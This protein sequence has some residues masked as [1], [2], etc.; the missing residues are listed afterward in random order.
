MFVHNIARVYLS[1]LFLFA[2]SLFGQ[3]FTQREPV[4]TLVLS[5]AGDVYMSDEENARNVIEKTNSFLYQDLV[6]LLHG[7]DASF[8]DLNSP[9]TNAKSQRRPANAHPNQIEA[10]VNA[11]FDV[12]SLANFD[13]AQQGLAGLQQ[14]QESWQILWQRFPWIRYS[15]LK[16]NASESIKATI[17]SRKNKNI[18]L[19]SFVQLNAQE[20]EKNQAFSLINAVDF[21]NQ[22]EWSRLLAYV[23]SL[24]TQADLIIVS[25]H[26][27]DAGIEETQPWQKA[28]RALIDAGADIVWNHHRA[29]YKKKVEFYQDRLIIHNNGTLL[30]DEVWDIEGSEQD[31]KLASSG[32]SLL[33]RLSWYWYEDGD[34]RFVVEAMPLSNYLHPQLGR[35]IIRSDDMRTLKSLPPVWRIYYERLLQTWP[36]DGAGG[37][38]E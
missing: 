37:G 18:A 15:G 19:L 30:T 8:L 11:G 14:T 24:R 9:V 38:K 34:Q 1:L 36:E 35:L 12:F 6:P 32:H 3:E 10:M 29:Q 26:G 28:L 27:G 4:S 20:R 5:L 17:F 33:Y 22:D 13:I 7:D 25:Y 2:T 16:T 23:K 21:Q 31:L